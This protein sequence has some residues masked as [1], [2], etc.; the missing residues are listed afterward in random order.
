[1]ADGEA[2]YHVKHSD[3]DA[4]DLDDAEMAEAIAAYEQACTT[5]PRT[6]H[7]PSTNLP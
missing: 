1:M 5:P 6:F 3:G 2:L 4:E 7:K